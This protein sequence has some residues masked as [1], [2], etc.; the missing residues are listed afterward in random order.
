MNNNQII[1]SATFLLKLYKLNVPAIQNRLMNGPRLGRT[2]GN[3]F[4][5]KESHKNHKTIKI[6]IIITT[7]V[8]KIQK[9]KNDSVN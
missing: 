3:H 9:S 2:S 4:N 7:Q 5:D 8:K 1:K 6:S